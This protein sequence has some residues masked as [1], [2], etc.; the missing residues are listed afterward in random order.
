MFAAGIKNR[1]DVYKHATIHRQRNFG[2]GNVGR[3]LKSA[4]F[5]KTGLIRASDSRGWRERLAAKPAATSDGANVFDAGGARAK[6]RGNH[7]VRIMR[8][9]KSRIVVA[10]P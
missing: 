3:S 5:D 9:C 8:D 10:I 6:A 1:R 7:A 2:A 4:F